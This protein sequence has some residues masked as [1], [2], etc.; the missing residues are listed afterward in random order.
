VRRPFSAEGTAS[1][2][3]QMQT[4]END[5]IM[6]MFS[7][8]YQIDRQGLGGDGKVPLEIDSAHKFGN[9]RFFPS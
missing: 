6:K 4:T 8:Y 1:L 7:N 3:F 5:F 2:R 9:G